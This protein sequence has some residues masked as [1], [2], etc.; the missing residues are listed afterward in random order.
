MEVIKVML[1]YFI[2]RSS[3]YKQAQDD[4]EKLRAQKGQLEQMLEDKKQFIKTLYS[5]LEAQQQIHLGEKQKLQSQIAET[6]K[7]IKQVRTRYLKARIQ[8]EQKL[9]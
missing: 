4:N 3:I 9:K 2:K 8:E 6:Q 1:N 7:Q 5:D